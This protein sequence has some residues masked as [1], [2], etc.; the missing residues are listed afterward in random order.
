[1]PVCRRAFH[2]SRVAIPNSDRRLD[3]DRRARELPAHDAVVQPSQGGEIRRALL[4][5]PLITGVVLGAG[6]GVRAACTL[7]DQIEGTPTGADRPRPLLAVGFGRLEGSRGENSVS[8]LLW[9]SR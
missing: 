9:L 2:S 4:H 1:M 8:V 5:A 7:R 6:Q 3:Q